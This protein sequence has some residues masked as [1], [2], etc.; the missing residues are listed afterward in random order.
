MKCENNYAYGDYSSNRAPDNVR[1][2]NSIYDGLV[3]RD[4]TIN[5]MAYNSAGLIDP[6]HGHEDLEQSVIACAGNPDDCFSEDALRILRA[7][8][9]ASTYNFQI[10]RKTAALIHK[11]KDKIRSIA[12]KRV[13]PEFCKMLCGSGIMRVLLEFSDIMTV[14]IPE[15][16][17]CIGFKQN[18][19]YHQYTVYEHIANAEGTQE[20]RIERCIAL[21]VP[22]G[23]PVGDVLR[24][25]FGM[26]IN[27]ELDNHIESQIAEA[28]RH[29]SSPR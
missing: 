14:I 17:P 22:E 10:D 4:F 2:V 8:R 19:R 27:E 13:W 29:L 25:I 18:N 12:A 6:F 15:L 28:K 21:G 11:N 20:S 16:E 1:F 26:V 23:K 3:R 7:L 24:H 9:L 5:A